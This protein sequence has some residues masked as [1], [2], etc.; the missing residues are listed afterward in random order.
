[1]PPL[2]NISRKFTP[3]NS[4]ILGLSLAFIETTLIKCPTESIKTKEMTRIE[5]LKLH[6]R[7]Q[8]VGFFETFYSGYTSILARQCF[9]WVTFLMA[10]EFSYNVFS[11]NPHLNR[12]E[13][14]ILSGILAGIINVLL[15]SPFDVVTTH[16]QRDGGLSKMKYIDVWKYLIKN[17]GYSVFLTAWKIKI[18][19]SCGY[20]IVFQSLINYFNTKN[21]DDLKIMQDRCND[22]KTE[23]QTI[24]N[25]TIPKNCPLHARAADL[26]RILAQ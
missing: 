24:L 3:F 11:K 10:I 7:I 8:K 14:S 4:P 17:H 5:H 6:Q 21:E 20:A 23:T 18:I 22:S 12:N 1:L 2:D 26:V 16:S 19:R 13:I 25:G 15:T 9:S